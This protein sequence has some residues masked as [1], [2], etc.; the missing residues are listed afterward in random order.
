ML[1]GQHMSIF[2]T[3]LTIPEHIHDNWN[4]PKINPKPNNNNIDEN[5]E[6]DNKANIRKKTSFNMKHS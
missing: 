3:A 6:D 5:I 2:H 1:D 4:D